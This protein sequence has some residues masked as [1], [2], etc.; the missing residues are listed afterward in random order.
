MTEYNYHNIVRQ[1]R[2]FDFLRCSKAKNTEH[3]VKKS[4]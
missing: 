2:T 3:L 4:L 1:M